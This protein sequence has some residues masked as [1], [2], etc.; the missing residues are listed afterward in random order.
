MTGLLAKILTRSFPGKAPSPGDARPAGDPQTA[1]SASQ[2]EYE[3]RA[4]SLWLERLSTASEPRVFELGELHSSTLGCLS[5]RGMGLSVLGL[6]PG[7]CQEIESELKSF[8]SST[9]FSGALCWD[10]PNYLGKAQLKALGRW[11]AK[12]LR[13]D[14]VV[15]VCLAT[16]I[17]YPD[18]PGSYCV[19]DDRTLRFQPGNWQKDRNERLTSADLARAWPEFESVR[20]FLLRNGMQEYVMKRRLR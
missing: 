16:Q 5:E 15:L 4:F 3:S 20:S 1:D 11:L 13:N 8:T 14:G 17:P 12:H 6:A 7:N 19:V 2:A 9:Q 10:I 18:A